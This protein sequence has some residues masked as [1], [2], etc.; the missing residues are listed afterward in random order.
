VYGDRPGCSQAAITLA[1]NR[2]DH[3]TREV[4]TANEHNAEASTKSTTDDTDHKDGKEVNRTK[5]SPIRA[6]R[7][8]RGQYSLQECLIQKE[9]TA[10][11]GE[12]WHTCDEL[13][14]G[15]LR[16]CEAFW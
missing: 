7:V 10:N 13:R 16:V 3:L 4:S 6:I 12:C 11:R 2:F 9:W 1:A 5:V 8:I 15:R 14:I